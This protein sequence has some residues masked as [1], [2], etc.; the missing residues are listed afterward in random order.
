MQNISKDNITVILH[1]LD[2]IIH[3]KTYIRQYFFNFLLF[4]IFKRYDSKL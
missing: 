3:Q 2:K 1:R 4:D